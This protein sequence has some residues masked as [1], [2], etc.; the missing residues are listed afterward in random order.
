MRPRWLP[1]PPT[2]PEAA[3]LARSIGV[4]LLVG[5]LLYSRGVQDAPSAERFLNPL[6]E[7]LHDPSLLPDIDAA[8]DRLA[9]AVDRGERIL[10]HGD[11]D[12]DGVCAAALLTRVLRVL[13]ADVR[14]F[15]PHRIEDGYDLQP[16]TVR[17]AATE[18]TRLILTTDCG[19]VAFESVALA[20]E[21]GIDVIV[22]DHHEPDPNGRLPDAVAVVNPHRLDSRYPWPSISGTAVAFKLAT[23]LVRKRGIATASFAKAYLDLVALATCAD[24]MPLRDENRALVVHGLQTLRTTNKPG[25]K[26]LMKISRVEPDRLNARSLGFALGPRINAVGRMDAAAHALELLLTTDPMEAELLARRLDDANLERQKEQTR[27]V[28]DA[29]RIAERH[30][31]DPVM[32][33]ASHNWMAGIIG[34][35]AG[36][37]TE[38]HGRPVVLIAIDE[39]TGTGRGSCRSIEG[40]DIRDALEG[41]REHLN[42]FG[43]HAAAAGFDIRADRIDAFR[44]AL[45]GVAREKMD[46]EDLSPRLRI[47]IEARAEEL[48][49]KLAQELGRLEPFGVDN[50]EPLI[51]CRGLEV[52]EQKRLPGRSE[53]GSAHMRLKF[54]AGARGGVG[55]VFWQAWD[56]YAADCAPGTRVDACFTL[57]TNTWNGN[58]SAQLDLK[59]LR[60]AEG[61]SF[62]VG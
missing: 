15:V 34:I 35:V 24:C 49:L 25:L 56:R 13:K 4:S 62:P 9:L 20:R 38:V 51:L 29:T 19:I 33:L 17:R 12:V 3:I 36:R 43:G 60:P 5:G 47:D 53:S 58:T 18:G 39:E 14:E 8:V 28:T 37:M 42:R 55:A 22:T 30:L 57:G 7:H 2:P 27:I 45:C 54:R 50:P 61:G 44:D 32:V 21:L 46:G 40:F 41:C 6:L 26:A 16:E 48:D 59:D 31:D 23:A 52:L 11:Y 10:V 1:P